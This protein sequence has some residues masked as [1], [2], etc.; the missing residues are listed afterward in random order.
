MAGSKS[1]VANHALDA[2]HR[3]T[4]RE[5]I[6]IQLELLSIRWRGTERVVRYELQSDGQIVATLAGVTVS[7]LLDSKYSEVQKEEIL[8]EWRK[9]EIIAIREIIE[10]IPEASSSFDSKA[11]LLD[12]RLEE[13]MTSKLVCRV[14]SDGVSWG[15]Y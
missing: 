13:G 9:A 14:S 1:Y 5:W 2:V 3:V 10:T 11:V 7:R 4:V 12:V 15:I 8:S 6:K